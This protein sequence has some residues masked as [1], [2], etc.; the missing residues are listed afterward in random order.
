MAW[1]SMAPCQSIQ[2]SEQ[3]GPTKEKRGKKKEGGQKGR[4]EKKVRKVKGEEARGAGEE[5]SKQPKA[6]RLQD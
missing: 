5:V 2:K 1:G 4:E 6:Q 3:R